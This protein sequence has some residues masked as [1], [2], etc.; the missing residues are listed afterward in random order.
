MA[1]L[2]AIIGVQNFVVRPR[3]EDTI[4]QLNQPQVLASAYLSSGDTRSANRPVV[5]TR[6]GTGFVLFIDVPGESNSAAYTAELYS[7][8]GVKEWSLQIAPETVEAAHG[9]LPIRV[10]LTHNQPGTYVLVLL[11]RGTGGA[12][13][14][15]IGRYPFE[16]QFQ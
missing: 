14:R 2:L 13:S 8:A 1:I 16:L 7:P 15:V 3:L 6:Q 9:T 10:S 5:I 11:R 4:A 12:E